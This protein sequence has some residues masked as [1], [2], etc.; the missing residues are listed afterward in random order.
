MLRSIQR[1]RR[2]ALEIM[3]AAISAVAPES[4][5][6]RNLRL[7]KNILCA[8]EH[9]LDITRFRRIVVVGA[10]K[11]SAAMARAVEHELGDRISDG[12]V[13]V[14]YGHSVDLKK[15][16]IKEAGH[17][18]PDIEGLKGA[19]EVLSMLDGCGEGDLV[20]S[21]ISGG[22]SALLPMPANGISLEEKQKVSRILLACGADIHEM[23]AVRKHLSKT[24]GG[25]LARAAYPATVVNL[26]L[27][28]VVG[29]DI[30]VI[31]S[32][33]FVPDRSTFAD[34]LKVI[35][36]YNIEQDMPEVVIKHLEMGTD[37]AIEET[38]GLGDPVFDRVVNMVIAS[39]ITACRAALEK[40]KDMGYNTLV[41]SSMIEGNTV[42][43]AGVHV[44]IARE[45]IRSSMPV[46]APACIISGGE[47][48]VV[49]RGDGLGGRNQE[50]A[51]YSAGLISGLEDDVVIASLGT[52][53]TDGP[54]DAAGGIVDPLTESRGRKKGL[55]LNHYLD[56]NDSYHYLSTTGD[57]VKTG[58]TLTNVMDIHLVLVAS[59][60]YLK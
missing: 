35:E 16:R 10:G 24:K 43:V 12:L 59:G 53:G 22:G 19:E 5:V 6:K 4:A 30:D 42:D 1:L 56:T 11:A 18:V 15:V 33:P 20:I 21:L 46:E 23:N 38:P 37:G 50:F 55:D 44:A 14:K 52:D 3:D 41:L 39:N 28:D 26:M 25:L 9:E 60:S 57:L 40:A 8:G 7:K 2:H 47:T 31:A 54:T 51:L 36:R 34:A 27:S 49:V 29:D 45:I 13:V 58:P 48:T 17:P 32:G